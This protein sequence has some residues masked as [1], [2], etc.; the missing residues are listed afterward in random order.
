MKQNTQRGYALPIAVFALVVVGVITTAGF[1]MARQEGRIGVANEQAG[2]AFY[3]TEQGLVDVISDW[4][5][6]AFAALPLWGDTTLTETYSD[7]GNVTTQ[8]TRMTDY[9]YFLDATG[10][11][12]QGGDRLSGASRRVG[13][14][15]RLNAADIEP[16]AALVV[17]GTITLSG[18]AEIHGEDEV[19]PGWNSQCTGAIEDK[20]GII[21][22]DSTNVETSGNAEITGTPQVQQDATIADST[23]TM[24]GDLTWA[25]LTSLADITITGSSI[26]TIA[27]DSTAAGACN[28]GQAFLANW[29]N[30]ENLGAA[31]SDWFPII[32]LTTHVNI[33]GGGVGQGVILAEGN[34][35]LRGNFVF[36]GIIIA[37]GTVQTQGS[38]NRIYGGVM[39]GNADFESQSLTGGS[40]L[41]NSTCAARRAV[42]NS[43]GLTR[44][45]PLVSRSW[46][47][48]SAVS[49]S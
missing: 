4:D 49:G 41:T 8:I 10:T 33:Q 14:M 26:S 28:T 43:A 9:L 45:R 20:P 17:R 5:K 25:Q 24:F 2:T 27:P 32:H 19:P 40:V 16:P 13:M 44:V 46:V 18:T 12:T 38:G 47:D 31:C 1:F 7:V 15:L 42:L 34:V 35:D 3:L 37:Q 36:Y 30:P 48:L 29:G 6:D 11:V 22:D 39:A 23:F 21:T